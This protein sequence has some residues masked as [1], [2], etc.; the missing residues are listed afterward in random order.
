MR[1][2]A[3][4]LVHVGAAPAVIN[5]MRPVP[6][7]FEEW[8]DKQARQ[9][10]AEATALV[11]EIGTETA[12]AVHRRRRHLSRGPGPHADLT[13]PGRRDGG[14]GQPGHG[15]VPAVV[16]SARSAPVWFT[17]PTAR[18]RSSRPG[19][20]PP[21]PACRSASMGLPGSVGATGSR[22]GEASRRG[23][24]L[25]AV[26]AWSDDSLFTV[27]GVDWSA[28]PPVRRNSWRS[29]WRGTAADY[30]DVTVHRV[31]VR[32][33]P[34]PVPGRA[35]PERPAAGS[36]QPRSGGFAGLLLGSVST[37]LVPHRHHPHDCRA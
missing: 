4:R 28:W 6:V 3:L 18:S 20:V 2:V 37:A 16:C 30:P 35:G 17:T 22:F 11:A 15:R 19:P 33:Q 1:N 34:T 5:V 9:V 8:Q 21:L 23:V 13:C 36:R 10:L 26:H 25:V 24:D 31:V 27:P 32:D 7:E 29:G 12:C 14:G